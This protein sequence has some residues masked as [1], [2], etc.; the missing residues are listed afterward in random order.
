[1]RPD[2]FIYATAAALVFNSQFFSTLSPAS[3]T[4]AAFATLGVGLVARPLGGIVWGHF[5][6]RVGRKKMLVVSLL[7]MGFATVGVGLLPTYEQIGVAAPVLLVVLRLLQGLSAGGEWGGAALMSVEHAPPGKR[8]RYGSFPQIGVPAG[9]ILAQLVFLVVSNVT[10]PEQFAAWGW[11]IPFLL[12]ILLVVVGLMIRLRVEESPVFALLRENRSRSRAPILEVFRNRPR[13]L[14]LASGSFIANNAIGYVF[15]AYLLAYGTQVL[16]VGRNTMILVVIIG[17]FSWLASI[18][19]AAIWSDT[20]GRRP[21]YLVGSVLLVIWPIPFFL[22]VDT[23]AFGAMVVAVVV[24]TIGLGLSY[25]PQAALFAEMF[26]ARFRYSGVSFC[27]AIGAVLGGGFAPL[28]ATALQQAYGTSMAVAAY[29]VVVALISLVAVLL[30]RETH[31]PDS[32][33]RLS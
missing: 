29:M 26:E 20:V 7:L 8:G 28:I 1:M 12:S 32:P 2:F 15:L 13:E 33:A 23:A 25:G 22:L 24:L 3:G 31:H 16:E 9:L 6:D 18:V 5:G 17:S 14:V 30:I 19:V 27:Y 4:L 11:R 21:V 10:T